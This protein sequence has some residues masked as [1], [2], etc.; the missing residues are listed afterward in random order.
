MVA[1]MA[2]EDGVVECKMVVRMTL[3]RGRVED[4][5]GAGWRCE[6]K[7]VARMAGVGGIVECNVVVRRALKW[8]S[9]RWWWCTMALLSGRWWRGWH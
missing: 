2:F 7:M 9:G 1:R 5:G 4:G 6:W 8:K 3:K